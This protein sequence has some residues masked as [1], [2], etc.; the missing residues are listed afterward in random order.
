MLLTAGNVHDVKVANELT[1][2]VLESTVIEDTG[3]DSEDHRNFLRSNN[4]TPI[5]PQRCNAKNPQ[6]YDKS[7]YKL[8]RRIENT[9][10]RLK[11][12]KRLDTRFDK[13]DITFYGFFCLG[14]IKNLL[15][16]NIC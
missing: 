14:F 2:D 16:I 3:Y 13:L 1:A 11:E 12:N 9:F 5:I 6:P 4:N 10:G 7:L 15:A 8:R